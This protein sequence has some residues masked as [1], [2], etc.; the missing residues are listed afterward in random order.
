MAGDILSG[1]L[2]RLEDAPVLRGALRDSRDQLHLLSHAQRQD[3]RGLGCG[4]SRRLLL[5]PQGASTHHASPAAEGRPRAAA[6]FPR[7]RA[8]ARLQARADPLSVAAELQE[9]PL[10]A[11]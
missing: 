5:Y 2:R 1:V 7:Y 6:L 8:S 3:H 11:G 10:T 9:G 4:D